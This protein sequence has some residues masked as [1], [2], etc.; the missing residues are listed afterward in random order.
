MKHL[1][2]QISAVVAVLLAGTT[3]NAKQK[4]PYERLGGGFAIAAVVTTSA[5]HS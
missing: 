4:T 5:T 2:L 1:A 3:A